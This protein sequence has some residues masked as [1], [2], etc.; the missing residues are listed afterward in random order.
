MEKKSPTLRRGSKRFLKELA[1]EQAKFDSSTRNSYS[2]ASEKFRKEFIRREYFAAK[3]ITK[4]IE[5]SFAEYIF[6]EE[7]IEGKWDSLQWAK[8]P[9]IQKVRNRDKHLFPILDYLSSIMSLQ[10]TR[11]LQGHLEEGQRTIAMMTQDKKNPKEVIREFALF[12]LNEQDYDEATDIIDCSVITF[13]KHIR[14]MERAGI[15]LKICDGRGGGKDR[16][17]AIYAFGYW[18]EYTEIKNGE[19]VKKYRFRSFLKKGT[20]GMLIDFRVK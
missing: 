12:S 9:A 15:V 6:D 3:D 20:S 13:K 11:I 2:E 14:G 18:Q 19:K 1:E 7:E 8:V 16:K 10:R 17:P 5:K 4:E